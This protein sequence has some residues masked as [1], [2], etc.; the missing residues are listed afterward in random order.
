MNYT[1]LTRQAFTTRLPQLNLHLA[2][3]RV[4]LLLGDLSVVSLALFL[5]LVYRA[6]VSLA[7]RALWEQ[8][9]WFALMGLYWFLLGSLFDVYNLR[10]AS[11]P[12]HALRAAGSAATATVIV[13]LLTPYLPPT[14]PNSR[15]QLLLLPLLTVLG[16]VGWRL[17]YAFVF[18]MPNFRQTA[19]VIG[20]GWAGRTLAQ[21][22]H[23]M[24]VDQSALGNSGLGYQ[25]LGFIDDDPAKQH[26][27]ICDTPILGTHKNLVA[28][29]CTL[30]PSQV[31]VAITH[32]QSL[33]PDLFQAILDCCE[34]GVPVTT[35]AAVYEE[36]TGRVPVEHAGHN[37]NVV[38][39]LQQS[40]T[41][42]LYAAFRRLFDIV[43]GCY[44]CLFILVV[45]PIIWVGNRLTS[46]GPIF[47]TQ[48]RT[49]LGGQPFNIL[50]F[51]SM[52]VNAEAESGAVWAAEDDPRITPMGHLIRK[53]R[54]DEIPQFWN[55]LK[56]DMSLI[57]PRP[58]RPILIAAL[59]KEIPFY[60]TRHAVR[61][62]VSGWA[63]VNYPYGASVD[64]A[65]V[66]LQ[67]DLYYIKH[68]G[69][70]IDLQIILKTFGV[71]LGFKGR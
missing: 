19:L 33:H 36:L 9:P 63:Q 45:M 11:R 20:A 10:R 18:V 71:V 44:G 2:E 46:P 50:K 26:Q 38:L 5:W 66:K 28:L 16:V 60:Q 30:Q 49:G 31:V 29:V 70:L 58:E 12:I 53:T 65:L 47:Y 23:E 24:D 51:R 37:L 4:L 68:Q 21:T 48:E 35:M 40:G 3:R 59:A 57:G 13:Y 41:H 1:L 42:R 22:L 43:I 17:L 32:P 34:L 27:Q 15:L 64:D 8:L 39:S 6:M 25:I 69:A 54:I 14:L 67:Y 55:V 56:G 62:G 61:P 52:T 7:P